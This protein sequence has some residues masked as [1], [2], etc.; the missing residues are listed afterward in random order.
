MGIP[1]KA[2]SLASRK[3]TFVPTSKKIFYNA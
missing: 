1:K 2:P 3:E